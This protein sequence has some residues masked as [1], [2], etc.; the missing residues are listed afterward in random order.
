MANNLLKPY[1][2]IHVG[3]ISYSMHVLYVSNQPSTRLFQCETPV[4]SSVVQVRDGK[5]CLTHKLDAQVI[6]CFR[7]QGARWGMDG[8]KGW[9]RGQEGK[10][11]KTNIILERLNVSIVSQHITRPLLTWLPHMYVALS[12]GV[13][14][15]MPLM[16]REMTNGHTCGGLAVLTFL[17]LSPDLDLTLMPLFSSVGYVVS[18]AT[19]D[20]CTYSQALI[21]HCWAHN[22]HFKSQNHTD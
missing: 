19:S 17:N 21:W 9:E 13:R 1:V 7:Q 16:E 4:K 8:G 6:C 11:K 18:S 3:V 15:H 2:I 20:E 12:H 10:G 5:R 14:R 22:E